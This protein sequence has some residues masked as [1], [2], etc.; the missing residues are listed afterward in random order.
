MEEAYAGA[1]RRV[2][3]LEAGRPRQVDVQVPAGISD[4]QAIRI[5]GASRAALK[6]RIKV[7][8]HPLY[9]LSGKDVQIELP[10]AP[11]E[12]ALGTKVAVPTLGGTVELTIP[13]GAQ[14]GQKLRLRGRGMPAVPNGDQLVVIKLVAPSADTREAREAYERMKREFKF[15]A[16]AGWPPA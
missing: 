7:R 9:T 10:L 16:R 15:D 3:I 4:G 8:P 12:A 5:G 13:A 14:S 2:T 11:W 6:F 1:R